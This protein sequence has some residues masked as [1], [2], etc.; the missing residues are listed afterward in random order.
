MMWLPIAMQL[1]QMGIG[2]YQQ[3]SNKKPKRPG[4]T[5]PS[6]VYAMLGQMQERTTS[7]MPGFMKENMLSEGAGMTNM[8]KESSVSGAS[9]QGSVNQLAGNISKQMTGLEIMNS[10]FKDTARVDYGNALLQMADYKDKQFDFNKNQPYQMAMNEYLNKKNS[11]EANLF[12]GMQGLAEYAFMGDAMGLNDNNKGDGTGTGDFK[13]DPFNLNVDN[14]DPNEP[15]TGPIKHRTYENFGSKGYINA[16]WR[17]M[18]IP[19]PDHN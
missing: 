13:V 5:I 10:Q 12:G 16:R 7:G 6:E 3:F 14:Y 15:W 1:A 8:L 18:F 19:P 4:Y 17:N 2:A 11:A 9:L